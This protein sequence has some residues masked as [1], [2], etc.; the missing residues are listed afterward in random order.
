MLPS[1]RLVRLFG[2]LELIDGVE[3]F[4]TVSN[5]FDEQ[6]YASSYSAM[7]VQPGAPRTVAAG[8]RARF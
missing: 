8:L 4:G 2:N 7:W 3:L 5:L 1:H 6:W